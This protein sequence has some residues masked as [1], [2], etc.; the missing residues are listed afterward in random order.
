MPWIGNP[1][2]VLDL[3]TILAST[4]VAF[5]LAAT[6]QSLGLGGCTLYLN[7]PYVFL[8]TTSSSTGF[9]TLG[10]PIPRDPGFRGATVHA[11]AFALDPLGG[12]AGMAF[13]SAIRLGLGD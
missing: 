8:P 9:A 12:F 2:Y 3:S 6:S 4:P 7:S 5:G 11:Q 10:F 1:Q 13:S